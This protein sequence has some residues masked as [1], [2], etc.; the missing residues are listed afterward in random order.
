MVPLKPE[1]PSSPKKSTFFSKNQTPILIISALVLLLVVIIFNLLISGN[2]S[3][4]F[5]PTS[6]IFY[7]FW[8]VLTVA[9]LMAALLLGKNTGGNPSSKRKQSYITTGRNSNDQEVNISENKMKTP[10]KKSI[11]NHPG[12]LSDRMTNLPGDQSSLNVIN[13]LKSQLAQS[14]ERKHATVLESICLVI[15]EELR[16]KYDEHWHF[17]IKS[18][19][20]K[21][22]KVNPTS[23]IGMRKMAQLPKI[24]E[25][26]EPTF[27]ISFFKNPG[28]LTT[29]GNHVSKS[30]DTNVYKTNINAVFNKF[31]DPKVKDN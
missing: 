9:L 26:P 6:I 30:E 14:P 28:F 25:N 17:T 23:S 12:E 24:D 21:K 19:N 20:K 1:G 31:Q 7:V 27:K 18:A 5:D 8:I 22:I 16:N 4:L 13:L 2:I 15:Q 10:V 29:R 3:T 11:Y